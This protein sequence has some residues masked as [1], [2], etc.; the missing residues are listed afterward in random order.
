[1]DPEDLDPDPHVQ[2]ERWFADARNAEVPAPEQMALAT[3]TSAGVPSARM[4]LLR[5]HDERGFVFFTNRSS[6]KG[7]ELDENPRAAAV[8]YWEPLHRQVRLEGT[9]ETI[10][11]AESAAYFR[12]RPRES[13]I[14][15]WASPQSE[16]LGGRNEL[17]RL[18]ARV[19]RRY[20]GVEDVPLPPFWG[21]YR[22]V[23]SALEFWQGRPSRLH[24]RVRYRL[25]D[26]G[27][28]RE[29]LAP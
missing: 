3:S 21:G 29:R 13:R 22:I 18:V 7:R 19:E 8:L 25:T 11:R 6:R 28:V 15:A 4:V 27:W 1:M 5:G 9:V 26:R 2:F 17:E 10:S 12:T 14:S 20:E 23:P 24:D 16:R